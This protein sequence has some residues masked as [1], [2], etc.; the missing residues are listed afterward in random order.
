M[1]RKKCECCP[2][3][4]LFNSLRVIPDSYFNHSIQFQQCL[5]R[6]YGHIHTY[7]AVWGQPKSCPKPFGQA[8][9]NSKIWSSWQCVL[10]TTWWEGNLAE[11]MSGSANA[12]G[13]CEN[14]ECRLWTNP[15][16]VWPFQF[17]EIDVY[18]NPGGGG[19]PKIICISFRYIFLA[20]HRTYCFV[21]ISLQVVTMSLFFCCESQHCT[22]SLSPPLYFHSYYFSDLRSMWNFPEK[23]PV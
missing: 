12:N 9:K 14:T 22:S 7:W 19:S 17:K 3:H 18:T 5:V 23:I 15:V 4:S 2:C 21:K 16:S 13:C 1:H 11:V 6:T 10:K 20:V 8:D